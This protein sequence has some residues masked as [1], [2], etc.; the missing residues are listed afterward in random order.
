MNCRL[1]LTL[2]WQ[3][4]KIKVFGTVFPKLKQDK[5]FLESR[6]Q[7]KFLQMVKNVFEL[8]CEVGVD[9]DGSEDGGE[10]GAEVVI[11]GWW[12]QRC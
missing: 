9:E 2:S 5:K 8:I 1:Y 7:M 11:E 10:N 6:N 4:N 3:G 12:L